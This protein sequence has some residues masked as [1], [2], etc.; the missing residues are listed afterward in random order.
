VQLDLPLVEL[1]D[2]APAV[3]HSFPHPTRPAEGRGG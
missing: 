2:L 1:P 3:A